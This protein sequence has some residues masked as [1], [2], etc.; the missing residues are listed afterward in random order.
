[1]KIDHIVDKF[2]ERVNQ[3][4]VGI[5]A[6]TDIQWVDGILNRLPA[7]LPPSFVSLIS[8]YVFDDFKAGEIWFYANRGEEAWEDLSQAIFRDEIMFRVTT[9]D[10]F[11]HFAQPHD[12]SYDP[13]CFDI[14]RR[15]KSGEYSIVR[16]DHE[17][18]L[19]F[20]QTRV[21]SNISSSLLEFM[22]SYMNR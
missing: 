4:N 11:I 13:L 9:S 3:Q 8:R 22:E 5:Q 14:R 6:C 2:V 10:G 7:R 17:A 1:M 20:E 18:I 21:V 15:R 12:G 19:Q 16:L